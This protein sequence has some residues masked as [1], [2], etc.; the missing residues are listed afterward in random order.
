MKTILRHSMLGIVLLTGLLGIAGPGQANTYWVNSLTDSSA[1]GTFR[2]ALNQAKN[3]SGADEIK[4]S[5]SGTIHV[6]EGELEV[7]DNHTTVYG[8]GITLDGGAGF[9][10]CAAVGGKG[11]NFWEGLIIKG[12]DCLIDGITVQN[13]K[14]DGINPRDSNH[15]TIQNCTIRNNG[16]EGIEISS[17]NQCYIA[18]NVIDRNG[19]WPGTGGTGGIVFCSGSGQNTVFQ[20]TIINNSCGEHG[21]GINTYHS[22]GKCN[23]FSQNF[24]Y[25]N[26][27]W[28]ESLGIDHDQDEEVE[29]YISDGKVNGNEFNHGWDCP[30]INNVSISESTLHLEGICL[31][32]TATIE[33]FISDGDNRS[34]KTYLGSFDPHSSS[35]NV[36]LPVSGIPAGAG[37]VATATSSCGSTS[38]F[39]EVAVSAP[40]ITIIAIANQVG[41]RR[42]VMVYGDLNT[43][44]GEV[45]NIRWHE[46]KGVPVGFRK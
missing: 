30:V 2:W 21:S 8:S 13:F 3:H 27:G 1:S 37:I 43:G 38:P 46:Q 10:N 7:R 16:G 12:N 31:A 44:T 5:V 42:T 29:D 6:T 15:L 11:S 36:D 19:Q 35:F 4:F 24:I 20:N 9:S 25:G 40:S 45:S 32:G 17:C 26:Y 33:V 41:V 23:T 28:P 18:N 14:D 34:G 22:S 39:S